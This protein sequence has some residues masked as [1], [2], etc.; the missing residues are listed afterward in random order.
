MEKNG[1]ESAEERLANSWP[2]AVVSLANDNRV[3]K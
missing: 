2:M 1:Q 3:G